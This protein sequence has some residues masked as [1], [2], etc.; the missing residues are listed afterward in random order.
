[1]I[2][3]DNKHWARLE[4]VERVCEAIENELRV[5]GYDL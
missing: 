1:V 5:R 2:P 3:G 4:V